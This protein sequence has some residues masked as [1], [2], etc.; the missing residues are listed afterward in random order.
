MKKLVLRIVACLTLVT[1]LCTT[2]VQNLAHVHAAEA[3][4]NPLFAVTE[5][6][7]AA[8]TVLY[9]TKDDV[10]AQGVLFVG[11]GTWERVVIPRD[12]GAKI[13][14]LSKVTA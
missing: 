1:M 4:V 7:V 13:I 3:P 11:E 6:E 8:G 2:G 14:Y 9:L 5:E 10:D 12:L